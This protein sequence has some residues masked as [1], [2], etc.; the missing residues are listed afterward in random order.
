MLPT[1]SNLGLRIKTARKNAGYSQTAL[2]NKLEKTLRTVQKYESGEIEPSIA[3]IYS[4]AKICSVSPA[5][6]MGYEKPE[7]HLESLSDVLHVI[8]A[9]DKKAGLHFHI[10]VK[11]PPH[12]DEWSC[13]LCFDG[14]DRA[15]EHNADLCLFLERYMDKRDSLDSYFIDQD[16]FDRWFESELAYYAGIPLADKEPEALTYEERIQKRNEILQQLK[17]TAS[18]SGQ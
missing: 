1:E 17:N 12:F 14:K 4:I 13:S 15:A 10:D 5:T 16:D 9:L 6:L 18:E 11:R 2:A 3:I 8:Y 7:I